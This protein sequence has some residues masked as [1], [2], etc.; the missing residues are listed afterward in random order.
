MSGMDDLVTWLRAQLD[1]DERA[2]RAAQRYWHGVRIESATEAEEDH[3]R[4]WDPERVLAEVDAKR[5]ILDQIVPDVNGMDAQIE[6]EW[7]CGPR[8]EVDDPYVGD[9]LTKLLAL[10]YAGRSGYQEEWRPGEPA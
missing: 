6:G 1:D 5:R 4:R 3:A 2:A 7:G 9:T 10:P 8:D